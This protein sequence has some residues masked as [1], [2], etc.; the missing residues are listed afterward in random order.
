MFL[1]NFIMFPKCQF[2]L[3]VTKH[4]W[5]HEYKRIKKGTLKILNI[6][7]S[8][9]KVLSVNID[10]K[11]ISISYKQDLKIATSWAYRQAEQQL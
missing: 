3:A 2:L 9:S 8:K 10:E 6:Q 1:V 4:V 11:S 5:H 7:T